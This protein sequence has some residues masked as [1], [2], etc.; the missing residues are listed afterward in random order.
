MKGVTN[1]KKALK[2]ECCTSY[3]DAV[4]ISNT[5]SSWAMQ[6]VMKIFRKV[7]KNI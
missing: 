5:I 6:K 4:H 7:K 2:E 1:I 3:A